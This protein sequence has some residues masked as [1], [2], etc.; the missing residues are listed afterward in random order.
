MSQVPSRKIEYPINREGNRYPDFPLTILSAIGSRSISKFRAKGEGVNSGNL[1]R[2]IAYDPATESAD[3][4]VFRRLI[5]G[6]RSLWWISL[7]KSR[8]S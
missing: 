2:D 7:A 6:P 4:F 1:L 8:R 5:D 3:C